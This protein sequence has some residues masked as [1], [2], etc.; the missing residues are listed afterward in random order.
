MDYEHSGKEDGIVKNNEFQ[1]A[2]LISF[3][4]FFS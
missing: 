2:N 3:V 4:W 1:K